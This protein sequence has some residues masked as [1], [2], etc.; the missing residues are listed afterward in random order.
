[1][2]HICFFNCHWFLEVRVFGEFPFLFF[3]TVKKGK[4][5]PTALPWEHAENKMP[6]AG[7]HPW[8]GSGC[9]ERMCW[10]S[11]LKSKQSQ[12]RP[13]SRKSLSWKSWPL[14]AGP[15]GQPGPRR[16][17]Y[18]AHATHVTGSAAS[19]PAEPLGGRGEHRR[20]ILFSNCPTEHLVYKQWEFTQT[21]L[22][23]PLSLFICESYILFMYSSP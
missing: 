10:C 5:S 1:M 9:G 19:P 14:C 6:E 3:P 16:L 17:L 22:D 13:P 20:L 4:N 7:V 23:S 2:R 8:S 21:E 18:V 11:S 15:V 12:S